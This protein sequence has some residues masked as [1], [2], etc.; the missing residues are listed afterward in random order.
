MNNEVWK[1]MV[2]KYFDGRELDMSGSYMVSNIGRI[3]NTK[4]G[5][6]LSIGLKQSPVGK[7]ENRYQTCGIKGN[8]LRVHR[9]VCSAFVDGYR[10]GYDVD[11]IDGDIYN[12]SSDN[13]RWICP[14]EH[15][16]L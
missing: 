8:V 16:S 13:L 12:N 1:P 2:Y 14:V 10:P 11:H 5:Y 7:I 6:M 4:T 3:M 15:M 9:A